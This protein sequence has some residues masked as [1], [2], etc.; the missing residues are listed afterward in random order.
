MYTEPK[1]FAKIRISK[2]LDKA[3]LEK[4]NENF[5]ELREEIESDEDKILIAGLFEK[6]SVRRAN[7]SAILNLLDY[8]KFYGQNIIENNPEML[9]E[10]VEVLTHLKELNKIFQKRRR[11]YMKNLKAKKENK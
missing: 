2:T 1:A 5:R 9:P 3:K 6:N 10:A 11:K 7:V 4:Y 8:D